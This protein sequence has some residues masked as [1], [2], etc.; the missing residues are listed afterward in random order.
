MAILRITKEFRFEG[1]HALS[2]YNGKCKHI[3][4]HSYVLYV[5]ITGEPIK[6]KASAEYGMIMDFAELKRIVNTNII[7]LVD[8][9][10]IFRNDAPLSEE[11][12]NTYD[13]VINLPFQPTC[14][15]LIN[16]F[17]EIIMEK[18]PNDVRLYS[19]K[20]YETATSYVEW[21]NE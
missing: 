16:Y 12:N 21:I 13:N 14:E 3:H 20:L 5:T 6:D 10:L 17:A 1:A 19:L 11:I 15:N 9:A 2:D 7:D 8:H 4:G 18:L